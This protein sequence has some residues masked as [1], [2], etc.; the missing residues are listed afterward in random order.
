MKLSCKC[1]SKR[2]CCK[3]RKTCILVAKK[4]KKKSWARR[5]EIKA[6]E[7]AQFDLIFIQ[8]DVEAM[9]ELGSY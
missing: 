4:N 8:Q 6:A 5:K 2:K 1:G 7:R 3:Y 9:D